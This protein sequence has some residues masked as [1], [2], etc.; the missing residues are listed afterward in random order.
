[1][2]DNL[3]LRQPPGKSL[4]EYVHFMRQ[5]FDDY[6]ETCEM[7]NGSTTIHPHHLGLL[8]LRGIS[9]NAPFGQTK[10]CIINAFDTNNL[11][12]ADEVM[13][14]ILHLARNMEEE[15]TGADIPAPSGPPSPSLRLSQLDVDHTVDV[16]TPT[17]VIAED[18]PCP[19]STENV[20]P[21]PTSSRHVRRP[22]MPS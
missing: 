20:A 18:V 11:M 7:I 21:S 16:A 13:A 12:S 14:N 2:M 3:M 8:M 4:T 19:T 17:V 1:M 9:S 22:T 10:Q 15:L 6:N 5:T